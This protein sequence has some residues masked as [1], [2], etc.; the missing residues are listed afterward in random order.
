M[1]YLAFSPKTIINC[2]FSA[3]LEIIFE[4][5]LLDE[6]TRVLCCDRRLIA[7]EIR[8]RHNL[9][10]LAVSLT[11]LCGTC[12]FVSGPCKVLMSKASDAGN[13]TPI[14]KRLLRPAWYVKKSVP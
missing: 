2:N 1:A 6:V 5:T 11:G 14:A 10:F 3:H 12:F 13:A 7:H 8:Q 4:M 9:A